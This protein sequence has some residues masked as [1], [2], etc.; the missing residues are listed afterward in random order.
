MIDKFNIR[1]YGLLLKDG[2]LLISSENIDGF[3][4]VKFPGGGVNL[5]EGIADALQREF[6]EELD[7]DILIHNQLYITEQVIISSF[8]PNEQVIAIYYLVDT[9]DAIET[10][11]TIQPTRLGKDNQIDFNWRLPDEAVLNSLSFESDKNA[12]SVLLHL[13]NTRD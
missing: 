5:G 9:H 10:L 6:K 4:M 2:K 3:K 13:I 8:K 11:S 7:I 1:V 12:L